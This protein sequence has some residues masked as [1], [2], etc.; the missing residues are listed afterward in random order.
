MKRVALIQVFLF[1]LVVMLLG[2]PWYLQQQNK[3]AFA[4]NEFQI[5]SRQFS[6]RLREFL[7]TRISV[8]EHFADSMH[9]G[10]I[11]LDKFDRQALELYRSFPGFAAINH[12]NDSGIIDRVVPLRTNLPSLHFDLMKT[13]EFK[14]H[15]KE[16]MRSGQIGVSGP[17]ELFSGD[18]G[19]AV[20]VPVKGDRGPVGMIAGVFSVDKVMHSCF[21]RRELK[22]YRF[23][24]TDSKT[25]KILFPAKAVSGRNSGSRPFELISLTIGQRSW[26]MK[27]F[28]PGSGNGS[29]FSFLFWL[30]IIGSAGIFSYFAG[31]YLRNNHELAINESRFRVL[32]DAIPD[33]FILLEP[34][35]HVV[36]YHAP[37]GWLCC[38][39]APRGVSKID[40]LF[41]GAMDAD[42]LGR[43][44]SS[45]TN[46]FKSQ[47]IQSLE[48]QF[49]DSDGKTDVEL[50]VIP[51]G[52]DLALLM[53]RNIS[54]QKQA[55][56]RLEISRERYQTVFEES[57]DPIFIT[58]AAGR[59]LE[60]NRA[61]LDFFGAST[62]GQL[63]AVLAKDVYAD[64]S[65]RIKL[66]KELRENGFVRNRH[67]TLVRLDGTKREAMIS[68]RL[69]ANDSDDDGILVGTLH[70]I[71]ELTAL[72]DQLL[73][74]QKMESIGRLAGGV[75][76]DFNNIL[77]GVMGYA[78][79][80]KTKMP[81]THPFYDY[82]DTIERGAVRASELT[83]RLLGF[84]RQGQFSKVSLD[85]NKI[86]SDT[87]KL[88]Q[89]TI[90]KTIEV[91]L[92]LQD[93]IP[94][95]SGDPSQ[96]HQV[97]MNLCVNARDAMADG[98]RLTLSSGS[99]YVSN[100][101]GTADRPLQD[102]SYVFIRVE[103]TGT[104]MNS[105]TRQ[106]IFEPFFTTKEDKGTGLGLAMV[107]GVVQNHG[108]FIDV[109]SEPGVGSAFTVY[110]P[111]ASEEAGKEDESVEG[112]S[113]AY[114][115]ETGCVLF[116]DDEA[117]NRSLAKEILA[118][119]G[120]EVILASDGLEALTLYRKHRERIDGVVLDMIMP[121]MDGKD[122][123]IELKEM[124]ESVNVMLISGYSNDGEIK[125][126]IDENNLLFLRKPFKID[127]MVLKVQ[128]LIS[129]KKS[130]PESK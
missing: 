114:R 5:L 1:F 44:V 66:L 117:D 109:Q 78:S 116:V 45:V 38:G 84:A 27:V 93:G 89:S 72:Q 110:L 105:E 26:E 18:P 115:N 10:I 102:G 49:S 80:M 21:S 121:K 51:Y 14:K 74:A 15:F 101:P 130:D 96:I 20:L 41:D 7:K 6:I 113:E 91:K 34:N 70:D 88:L 83:A 36:D 97:I 3:T 46:C 31:R 61:G 42:A 103:D 108:G 57:Q 85:V 68:V 60:M 107:Y 59:L 106:K 64:K 104:G 126:L 28:Q 58:T 81:P 67:L 112:G 50:R 16:V 127:E 11:T 13:T 47:E 43:M 63:M 24:I 8:V 75:A 99:R 125:K 54:R 87:A 40:E 9:A 90:K 4:R 79:L 19:V 123:F 71:T 120:I 48:T 37:R 95:V 86:A 94:A 39:N 73:Q 22:T 2:G 119:H 30:I 69:L 52:E 12:I 98:G 118:I 17:M 128:K 124:D 122:V 62:M 25:G 23:I 65:D 111:V 35:G 77:S 32:L 92:D 76:H 129:R 53:V 56:K 29:I 55:E 33:A 100:P 82:V